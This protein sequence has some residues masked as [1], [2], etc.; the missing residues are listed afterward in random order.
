MVTIKNQM[1]KESIEHKKTVSKIYKLLTKYSEVNK[2]SCHMEHSLSWGRRA[3]I[4]IEYQGYRLVVEVTHKHFTIQDYETKEKEYDEH[5]LR[6][7][8]ILTNESM[9][10]L[11]SSKVLPNKMLEDLQIRY[12]GIYYFNPENNNLNIGVYD[13]INKEWVKIN[14]PLSLHPRDLIHVEEDYQRYVT[15]NYGYCLEYHSILM[16]EDIEEENNLKKEH[17]NEINKEYKEL[18]LNEKESLKS[19]ESSEKDYSF[20]YKDKLPYVIDKEYIIELIEEIDRPDG[21]NWNNGK[22]LG[23]KYE[24]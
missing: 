5:N 20:K 21:L 12:G 9:N 6:T 22:T 4:Y 8:H 23:V 18:D 15:S 7:F 11:I 16:E 14:K 3:D 13:Y 10:Y 2:R 17:F 1:N 19:S 24:G